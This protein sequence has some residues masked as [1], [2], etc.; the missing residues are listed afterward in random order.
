MDIAI[1]LRM[2]AKSLERQA[3]KLE[4]GEKANRKKI[5]DALNKGQI[6]NAKVHAE[7]VIRQNREAKSVRRFGVQMQSLQ[8]KIEGAARTQTMAQT[9][10][11][12]T[13]AL[14]KA[15]KQMDSAGVSSI[16]FSFLTN[17]IYVYLDWKQHG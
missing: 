5:L 7:T 6:D 4:A 10:A 2:Q 3:S 12:T 16:I 8:A 17:F 9:M 11:S 13:P 15:M 14:Q 1:D